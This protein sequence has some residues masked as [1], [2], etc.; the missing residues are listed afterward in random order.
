MTDP[1][2]IKMVLTPMRFVDSQSPEGFLTHELACHACWYFYILC[3]NSKHA[4]GESIDDQ[5]IETRAGEETPLWMDSYYN[6]QA[7]SVA[8]LYGLDSPA[9]F[10]SYWVNVRLEARRLGLTE[11]SDDYMTLTGKDRIT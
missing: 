4:V 7:K 8:R 1:K 11:P 3:E 6:Q 9:D 10:Q 2:D 5:I